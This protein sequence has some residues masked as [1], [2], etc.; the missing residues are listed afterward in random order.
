LSF[1]GLAVSFGAKELV[2]DLINGILTLFEGNMAVGDI[3]CIGKNIGTVESMSL[4]AILLRHFT[5]ELQTIPFSEASSLTNCSRD[6][7]VAPIL[8]TVTP[9]AKIAAIQESIDQAYRS[10]KSDADYSHYIRSKPSTVGVK[11]MTSTGIIVCSSISTIPDP[12]K[13]FLNEF[14]KRLFEELQTRNVPFAFVPN[15]SEQ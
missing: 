5:G 8:L 14:N 2:K 3:V 10:M 9:E 15:T 6:F 12:R 11:S 13:N 1:F 4:R 7:N